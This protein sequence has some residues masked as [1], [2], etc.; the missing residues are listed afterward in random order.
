MRQLGAELPYATTV[1]IRRFEEEPSEKDRRDVSHRRGDL[2]GT[3][4]GP[5]GDRD[6]QGAARS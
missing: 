2:G 6:R 5:E 4:G 3:R 1:E